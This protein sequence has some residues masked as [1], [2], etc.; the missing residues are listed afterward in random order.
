MRTRCR[1]LLKDTHSPEVGNPP[2][3]MGALGIPKLEVKK[4]GGPT[5]LPSQPLKNTQPVSCDGESN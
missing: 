3:G 2:L 1:I 5:A 4:G